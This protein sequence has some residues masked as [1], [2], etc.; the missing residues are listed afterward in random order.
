M[1]TITLGIQIPPKGKVNLMGKLLVRGNERKRLEALLVTLQRVQARDGK[2]IVASDP[3]SFKGQ[4]VFDETVVPGI[5]AGVENLQ[6]RLIDLL[7]TTV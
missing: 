4:L 1:Q 5:S 7:A 2:V 3:G 6:Q